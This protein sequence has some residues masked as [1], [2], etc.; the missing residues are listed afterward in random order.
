[1]L[2]RLADYTANGTQE[3]S[4]KF[5]ENILQS[6]ARKTWYVLTHSKHLATLR[7]IFEKKY[8]TYRKQVNK[9]EEAYQ[10]PNA[11]AFKLADQFLTPEVCDSIIDTFLVV[12]NKKN[13]RI[14]YNLF[15]SEYPA[16]F[17]HACRIWLTPKFQIISNNDIRRKLEKMHSED[18][19]YVGSRLH[20]DIAKYA[21][22]IETFQ[23]IDTYVWNYVK[24]RL[25]RAINNSSSNAKAFVFMPHAMAKGYAPDNYDKEREETGRFADI[26][27]ADVWNRGKADYENRQATKEQICAMIPRI[28]AYYDKYLTFDSNAKYTEDEV[29]ARFGLLTDTS[30]YPHMFEDICEKLLGQDAAHSDLAIDDSTWDNIIDAVCSCSFVN[31]EKIIA[32]LEKNSDLA[33]LLNHT[34]HSALKYALKNVFEPKITFYK[35][36]AKEFKSAYYADK[37]EKAKNQAERERVDAEKSVEDIDNKFITDN[38]RFTNVQEGIQQEMSRLRPLSYHNQ[39]QQS[40][41]EDEENYVSAW[42]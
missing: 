2:M 21:Q 23:N 3:V 34:S 28:W 26:Y 33:T 36:K 38:E 18:N 31:G 8:N 15:K 42:G 20:E 4:V 12:D 7:D 30:Q 29:K 1:M 16:V 37:K 6:I 40:R 17:S 11:P 9:T 35:N 14:P 24:D 5:T 39:Q 27:D 13:R 22:Q 41:L 10:F 25:K 19:S 32:E